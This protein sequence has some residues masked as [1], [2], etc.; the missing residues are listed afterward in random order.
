MDG[1]APYLLLGHCAHWSRYRP[2]RLSASLCRRSYPATCHHLTTEITP[3]CPQATL[4]LTTPK[5][6]HPSTKSVPA[7]ASPVSAPSVHPTS[8]LM[9]VATAYAAF[10]SSNGSTV[11]PPRAEM[12][13]T[14]PPP[15][16]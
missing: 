11:L 4:A 3:L 2:R 15:P 5:I 12:L 7:K 9:L 6:T 10:T 14:W 16:A 13:L 1:D 8:I